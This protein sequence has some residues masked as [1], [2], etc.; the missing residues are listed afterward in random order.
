MAARAALAAAPTVLKVGPPDWPSEPE[1]ITLRL[2]V[3]GAG[4]AGAK[5][6]FVVCDA[7]SECE[8]LGHTPVL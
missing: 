5:A 8:R 3:T 6:A 4:L 7:G 1:G 2:M